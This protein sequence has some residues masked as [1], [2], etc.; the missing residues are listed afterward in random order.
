M[1]LTEE[2]RKSLK[3]EFGVTDEEIDAEINSLT[4]NQEDSAVPEPPR[5]DDLLR[6][7]RDVLVLRRED[8]QQ[9]SRTGNLDDREIGNLK[10]TTRSYL[11]IANYAETE[12]YDKVAGYLRDKSN[13]AMTTS[14]SRRGFFLK[15]PFSQ[16]KI[17]RNLSNPKRTIQ[18]SLFGGSKEIV[19][20]EE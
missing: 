1:E 11:D 4:Q 7:I 8:Y 10:L 18:K 3:Q 9:I 19:E 13:I 2:E 12:N 20:G 5:K 17:S 6:F 16:T 15:L 14:L